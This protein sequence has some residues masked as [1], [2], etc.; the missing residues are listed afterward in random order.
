MP[1]RARPTLKRVKFASPVQAQVRTHSVSPA[2]NNIKH[3]ELV[4]VNFLDRTVNSIFDEQGMDTPRTRPTDTIVDSINK[5]YQQS[6]IDKELNTIVRDFDVKDA[7]YNE[8]IN[9][10]NEFSRRSIPVKKLLTDLGHIPKIDLLIILVMRLGLKTFLQ[11]HHQCRNACTEANHAECAE[12]RNAL[13]ARVT[14]HGVHVF[15]LF[16]RSASMG[17]CTIDAVL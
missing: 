15:N 7:E 2:T 5:T 6:R 17:K 8:V 11:N 13:E 14:K 3:V 1:K 12:F 10:I 9:L 4:L 16:L